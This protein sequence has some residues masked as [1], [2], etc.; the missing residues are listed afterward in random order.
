MKHTQPSSLAMM[1]FSL[2]VLALLAFALLLLSI[3][4]PT[5]VY[6]KEPTHTGPFTVDLVRVIDGDTI[7][8]T[9]DLWPNLEVSTH[10]RLRSVD[11][12]ELR[13]PAECERLLAHRA[14]TFVLVW[15]AE[16][17]QVQL[18]DVGIGKFAG[19][20]VGRLLALDSGQFLG[21]ALLEAGHGRE[22]DGGARPPW[23]EDE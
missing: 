14:R 16:H 12:P 2:V 11:T 17:D 23:C 8:A 20:T 5:P 10:V 7:A 19:R 15:I 4:F 1:A 21:D 13:A 6:A 9:V 22:Y 3:L 18:W